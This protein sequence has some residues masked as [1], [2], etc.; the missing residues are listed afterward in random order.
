MSPRSELVELGLDW[1]WPA[2]EAPRELPSLKPVEF[3]VDL[4]DLPREM[5]L[6][7]LR[8]K[9][10]AHAAAGLAHSRADRFDEAKQEFEQALE[11]DPNHATALNNFAWMLLT[12]PDAARRDASRA[13][14]LARRSVEHAPNATEF[15]NTLGIAHYRT[16][17]SQPAIDALQKAEDLKPGVY[18]GDN[19]FFIAMS[20]WQLG[21]RDPARDW[22]DRAV[23]WM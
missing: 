5:E 21:N 8:A 2:A 17:Q 10:D 11:H 13:L 6:A 23:E 19:A 14:E 12:H 16:G 15:W 20:H 3:L 7:T 9:A 4:G 22:F 18:F 1:E